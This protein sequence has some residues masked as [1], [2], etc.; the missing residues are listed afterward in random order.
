MKT[1]KM[2]RAE[3]KERI[4]DKIKDV[5]LVTRANKLVWDLS[6]DKTDDYRKIELSPNL[7]AIQFVGEILSE[8]EFPIA[9]RLFYAGMRRKSGTGNQIDEGQIWVR[10]ELV[11]ATGIKDEFTIPI[12]VSDGHMLPPSLV[13]NDGTVNIIA[14]STFDEILDR[15]TSY[16]EVPFRRHMFSPGPDDT[17]NYPPY[18]KDWPKTQVLNRDMFHPFASKRDAIRSAM[19][20][21]VQGIKETDLPPS[22]QERAEELESAPGIL[23]PNTKQ[24][25]QEGLG[26]DSEAAGEWPYNPWESS[27]EYEEGPE[28]PEEQ[29]SDVLIE[30]KYQEERGV[31]PTEYAFPEGEGYQ[32]KSPEEEMYETTESFEA[33]RKK[34]QVSHDNYLDES[35]RDN[36]DYL[37]PGEKF[38]LK[39]EVLVRNR[40]GGLYRI[41]SG[42]E[43]EVIRDI[44]G[45][46]RMFYAYFKDAH[47]KAWVTIHQIE[48]KKH[49]RDRQ[50]REYNE[51]YSQ[52]SERPR[53]LT[54][55]NVKA[56]LT[57]DEAEAILSDKTSTDS[58][59]VDYS[60]ESDAYIY[61]RAGELMARSDMNNLGWQGSLE[62]AK[63][64]MPGGAR[65]DFP[66]E[67]KQG[68]RLVMKEYDDLFSEKF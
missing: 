9:P 57:R 21:V 49:P 63:S 45:T 30:Q 20:G 25:I 64:F 43:G 53:E 1:K 38:K 27:P 10:A 54:A 44:D 35:E 51:G 59:Q 65:A 41:S 50:D 33:A 40:G 22:P 62:V 61:G 34:A 32:V 60:D 67:Y 4:Y 5:M 31:S 56:G 42:A 17:E 37:M 55:R 46:G 28:W 7:E 14:Q 23:D 58:Y 24:Y 52:A 2:R 6:K 39:G 12:E 3:R 68:Y 26:L 16:R 19:T 11:S 36:S 8:F 18:N 66:E 13:I 47:L 15:I 29:P 48:G